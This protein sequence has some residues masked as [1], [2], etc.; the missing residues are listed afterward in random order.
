MVARLVAVTLSFTARGVV[1]SVESDGFLV[2][3]LTE[4]AEGDG[5]W[6]QFQCKLGEPDE[7]ETALGID[8]YAVISSQGLAHGCVREV[9]LVDQQLRVVMTEDSLARLGFGECEV[10]VWL[11]VDDGLVVRFRDMLAQ[12]LTYGREDAR[13]QVIDLQR[14]T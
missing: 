14:A 8:T 2:A 5:L 13:P 9:A 1:T 3:V 4:S 6:L 7:R 10:R 11:D 12:I